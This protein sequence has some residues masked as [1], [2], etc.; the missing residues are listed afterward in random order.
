MPIFKKAKI[1]G[2]VFTGGAK[3]QLRE[4][5]TWGAAI[6][7]GLRQG[8][9]YKGNFKA[10]LVAGG[11]VLGGMAVAGGLYNVVSFWDDIERI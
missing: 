4:D 1:I 7:I 6:I 5:W 9:K 8:L 3:A 10:G 2:V 11:A